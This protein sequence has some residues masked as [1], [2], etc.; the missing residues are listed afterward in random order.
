MRWGW[1]DRD[2]NILS[3]FRID[4]QDSKNIRFYITYILYQVRRQIL[5]TLTGK[6]VDTP[7]V[8]IIKLVP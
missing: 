6:T 1:L 2:E 3:A 7:S 4:S 5:N 8:V